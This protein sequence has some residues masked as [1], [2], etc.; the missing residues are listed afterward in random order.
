MWKAA[1]VLGGSLLVAIAAQITVP[2]FPVPMT[3]QMLAV[4]V[5][6][7]A[8]GFRL[9]SLALLAYVAEGLMGLPVFSKG[10]AGLAHLFGPSGGYITGFVLAA[11]VAGWVADRGWSQ[12]LLTLIP[13]LALASIVL[14]IPGLLQLKVL[15]G[16]DWGQVWAWGAGPFLLGDSVKIV[17]AALIVTGGWSAL[18]ARKR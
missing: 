18:R 2:F 15:S 1:L 9:G 12:R 6:G 5:V 13:G 14:Y 4:L 16:A 7:A 8:L 10:G 17:L 3:L 11:A